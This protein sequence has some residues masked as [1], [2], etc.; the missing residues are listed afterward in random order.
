MGKHGP[1]TFWHEHDR[2]LMDLASWHNRPW[3]GDLWLHGVWVS[4]VHTARIFI[5]WHLDLHTELPEYGSPAI[6]SVDPISMAP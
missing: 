6:W 3:Q 4:M 5:S 2:C 1:W